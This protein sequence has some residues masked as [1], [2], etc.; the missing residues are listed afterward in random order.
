MHFIRHF[1][2]LGAG[3][4]IHAIYDNQDLRK[5]G[6][7]KLYLPLTYTSNFNSII[8]FNSFTIYVRILLKRFY[9]RICI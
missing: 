7:L 3:S 1:L 6:G 4:I 2:F 5:Y 9:F 8:K